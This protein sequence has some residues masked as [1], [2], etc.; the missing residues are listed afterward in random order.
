MDGSLWNHVE[1][2]N[3]NLLDACLK[4]QFLRPNLRISVSVVLG[5]TQKIPDWKT[6]LKVY[7]PFLIDWI[8]LEN[9]C[10]LSLAIKIP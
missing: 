6:S 10:G 9:S 5:C 3:Q 2:R 7:V 4:R 8:F 1:E